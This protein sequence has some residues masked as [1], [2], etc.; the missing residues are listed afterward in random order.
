MKLVETGFKGLYIIEP[1][2]LIDN[3]GYFMESFNNR[4]L[5]KVGLKADFVQDNQSFSNEGV[6][7]GL[8][9]QNAPFAQTKLVRVLFGTILD[10]VVDLRKEEPTFGK[11]YSIELSAESRQQLYVPAGFAH[12]FSV[13]SGNAEILYK[14]DDYY[15]RE[16][17]GGLLYSDP[18]LEIDWGLPT[19]KIILSDKDAKNPT[20]A[21]ANFRF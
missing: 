4:E 11:H 20:L 6:L 2:V 1:T 16:A 15:N 14:C 7:R 10:I 21:N 8:H 18:A 5:S 12:G 19:D 13:L 3:R 17:E 9:Y